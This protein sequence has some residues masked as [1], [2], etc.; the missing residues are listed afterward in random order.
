[1]IDCEPLNNADGP[2]VKEEAME[3]Y[4]NVLLWHGFPPLVSAPL[5]K[6]S[7]GG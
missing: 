6:H 3:G 1:M 7:H 2:L 4:R 5:G